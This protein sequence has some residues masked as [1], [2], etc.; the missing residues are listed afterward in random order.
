MKCKE[1][2]HDADKIKLLEIQVDELNKKL[3]GAE[4][5]FKTVDNIFEIVSKMDKSS[6]TNEEVYEKIRKEHL[7]KKLEFLRLNVDM[8]RK[9]SP[10]SAD[11]LTER[12]ND[13]EKAHRDLKTLVEDFGDIK[14]LDMTVYALIGFL[15][16]MIS[17][18]QRV[19]DMVKVCSFSIH[20]T[21]DRIK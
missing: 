13:F 15:G 1:C 6:Q 8:I 14:T 20:D 4:S 9:I 10:A 21:I 7:F 3:E 17:A 2:G 11:I 12:I 18:S 5:E 19:E 16:M